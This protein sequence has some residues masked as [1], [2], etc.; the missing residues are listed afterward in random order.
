MKELGKKTIYIFLGASG[1]GKTTAGIYVKENL[2]IPELISHTTRKPREGEIDGYTY[3]YIT[4]EEFPLIEKVESSNYSGEDLYCLSKQ[5]AEEKLS[6]YDKVFIIADIDGV[7][8]IKDYYEDNSQVDVKVVYFDI[9][10]DLIEER[11]RKRGDS[12]EDIKKRLNKA[13]ESKELENGKY[14]DYVLSHKFS[15]KELYTAITNIVN[16]EY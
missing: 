1:S 2:N 5:E 15:L 6:K 10:L 16:D 14:A 7:K 12:D 3:Y 8:Q 13:I 4:R 11:M 9:T